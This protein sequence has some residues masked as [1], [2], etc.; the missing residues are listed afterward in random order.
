LIDVAWRIRFAR[1]VL[2]DLHARIFS[3]AKPS[4]A[5]I[6]EADARIRTHPLP[7]ALQIRS[8]FDEESTSVNHADSDVAAF[9][10]RQ[11]ANMLREY[12]AFP[13]LSFFS[14]VYQF[15]NRL[16]LIC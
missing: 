9:T 4:Y 12:S 11:M 3:A 8:P 6:L 10:Q 7:P 2:G 13:S 5:C 14:V 1:D 15:Q 16:T